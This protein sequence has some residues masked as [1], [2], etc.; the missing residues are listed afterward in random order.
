MNVKGVPNDLLFSFRIY[1]GK[2][3]LNP[4]QHL[5]LPETNSSSSAL[6]RNRVRVMDFQESSRYSKESDFEDV[7]DAFLKTHLIAIPADNPFFD[8]DVLVF[9]NYEGTLPIN[10]MTEEEFE[11]ATNLLNALKENNSAGSLK[12]EGSPF[13]CSAIYTTIKHLCERKL[14][15]ELLSKLLSFQEKSII[16][17]IDAL[18]PNTSSDMNDNSIYVDIDSVYN[19]HVLTRQDRAKSSIKELAKPKQAPLFVI[20]AHEM[21]HL[22]HAN[23]LSEKQTQDK[24]SQTLSENF[25]IDRLPYSNM[26]EFFTITGW[27]ALSLKKLSRNQIWEEKTN[28]KR[29]ENK[30]WDIE[31]DAL[32]SALKPDECWDS[33]NENSFHAAYSIEPRLGHTGKTVTL[34]SPE[35]K[36][37]F[38]AAEAESLSEMKQIWQ[39]HVATFLQNIFLQEMAVWIVT[40]SKVEAFKQ[41][42]DLAMA[43]DLGKA[44]LFLDVALRQENFLLSSY[45]ISQA[46]SLADLKTLLPVNRIIGS[47]EETIDLLCYVLNRYPLETVKEILTQFDQETFASQETISRMFISALYNDSIEVPQFINTNYC[48]QNFSLF[49]AYKVCIECNS[50]EK[51][52]YIRGLQSKSIEP[53]LIQM[54]YSASVE[55]GNIDAFFNLLPYTAAACTIDPSYIYRTVQKLI[56]YPGMDALSLK[57]LLDIVNSQNTSIHTLMSICFFIQ[58]EKSFARDFVKLAPTPTGHEKLMIHA[59]FCKIDSQHKNSEEIIAFITDNDLIEIPTSEQKQTIT[60]ALHAPS[61]KEVVKLLQEKQLPMIEPY[62]FGVSPLVILGLRGKSNPKELGALLFTELASA[63]ASERQSEFWTI[64]QNNLSLFDEHVLKILREEI[65]RQFLYGFIGRSFLKSC[66][67]ELNKC[68]K[69]NQL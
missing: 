6:D 22:L 65:E 24:T 48:F 67:K 5:P 13:F 21:I 8:T 46:S 41:L 29:S 20:L 42:C 39:K 54:L 2:E 9:K 55:T 16:K 3:N 15:R 30:N 68:K 27:N 57:A 59:L 28:E 34:D 26:E 49:A 61:F 60:R 32:Q 62:W 35:K 23:R 38:D 11:K 18:H 47:E 53:S 7:L 40:F 10:A 19:Y 45:V 4:K 43:A 44:A 14:G 31:D 33:M 12:I 56:S 64:I 36:A 52:Q 66:K 37:F 1:Q 25:Y 58:G 50:V 63:E 51:A 69:P 17:P